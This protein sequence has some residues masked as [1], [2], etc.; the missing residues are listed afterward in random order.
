[1]QKDRPLALALQTVVET[2]G[3]LL[4]TLPETVAKY[5]ETVTLYY[6]NIQ[7]HLLHKRLTVSI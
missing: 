4:Q 7:Q 5:I 6:K 2:V 3:T 1:M